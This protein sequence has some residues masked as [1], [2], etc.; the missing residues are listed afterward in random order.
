M[1]YFSPKVWK[2]WRPKDEIRIVECFLESEFFL[3]I[4]LLVTYRYNPLPFI[5]FKYS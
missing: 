2:E 4:T 5:W 1:A 3:I